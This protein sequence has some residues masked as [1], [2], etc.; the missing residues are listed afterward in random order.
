MKHAY[1]QALDIR[2]ARETKRAEYAHS[3]DKLLQGLADLLETVKRGSY[4]LPSLEYAAKARYGE[5]GARVFEYLYASQPGLKR[6]FDSRKLVNAD[7]A[8]PVL[9]RVAKIVKSAEAVVELGNAY[10][11]LADVCEDKTAGLLNPFEL[12]PTN[13]TTQKT[14]ILSGSSSPLQTK[15]AAGFLGGIMNSMASGAGYAGAASLRSSSLAKPPSELAGGMVEDLDDP[16]HDGELRKI[17]SRA[18]LQDMMMN[19]E[20]ISGYDPG[21]VL[22][23]YNEIVG[24]TPRSATQAAIVRP[25]LRKRLTQGAIEPFEAAEMVNIEK[26]LGEVNKPAPPQA[27]HKEGSANVL[28]HRILG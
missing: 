27:V 13:S 21:E 20:V 9:D 25:L 12:A 1:N 14:S 24:V 3:Q 8:G 2:R 16:E 5:A 7:W 4:D 10:R 23:A 17:Q 19:D 6:A 11:E 26:G 28:Q 15:A 18:M 22:D